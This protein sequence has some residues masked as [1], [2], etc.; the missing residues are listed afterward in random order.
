MD[1][2]DIRRGF[3][4]G[5]VP[6][7]PEVDAHLK[8]CPPCRELVENDADLG[9]RLAHVVAPEVNAGDLFAQVDRDVGQEVG[10][11]ARLRALPTR[12]RVGALT[13][14]S[15]ALFVCQLALRG[16]PDFAAYSPG[17]FWGCAV[18]LGA[19]GLAGTVALMRGTS[20]PARPYRRERLRA[21]ALLALPALVALLV[22]FGSPSAAA[23]WSGPVACFSY[24]AALA[25]PILLLY[26]LLERRDD[27]P[28]TVLLSAGGLAGITANLLLHARCPSVH[29]GHLLLGHAS[30]GV[31]LALALGLLSKR[32][33]RA[34]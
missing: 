18:L 11:R 25:A 1:C 17:V 16:R 13:G 32:F 28:L 30:I 10:M 29:L 19:A 27:V 20:A 14:V 9:R 2:A 12:V 8:G 31:M 4:A 15:A 21:L 6:A 23:T 5:H 22:P 7:G 34:R 33:Q 26:W 24:G 3:V